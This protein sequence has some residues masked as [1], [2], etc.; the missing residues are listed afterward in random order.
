MEGVERTHLASENKFK[1]Y[2]LI[3]RKLSKFFKNHITYTNILHIKLQYR[4]GCPLKSLFQKY[5]IDFS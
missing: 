2:L 1:Y 5:H 3:N 4:A